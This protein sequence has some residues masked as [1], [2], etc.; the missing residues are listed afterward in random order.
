MLLGIEPEEDDPEYGWIVPGTTRSDN[1]RDVV[2]FREKP[3]RATARDLMRQG[4]LINSL[5]FLATGGALFDLYQRTLPELLRDFQAWA[6]GHRSWDAESLSAFYETLPTRDLSRDIL[7]TVSTRLSV[8]PVSSCG[9]LDIG[10][11]DRLRRFLETGQ[12]APSRPAAAR[13]AG[14]PTRRRL[15]GSSPCISGL[16]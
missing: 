15:P 8:V 3:D 12:A 13:G 1:V 9:W 11:P 2:S 10:T 7:E 14:A 4:A 16:S 5:I 6:E